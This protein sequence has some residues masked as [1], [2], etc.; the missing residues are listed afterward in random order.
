MEK[1]IILYAI[2]TLNFYSYSQ[3]LKKVIELETKYLECLDNGIGMKNCP[4]NF[5]STSDSLLNVAY[6]NLKIKMNVA[7]Q[8]NLQIEQ[9]KWLKK[10]DEYFKKAYVEAKKEN[11][12]ETQGS[13]FTMF[14]FNKK[15]EFVIQRVKELINRINKIK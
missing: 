10:R 3:T 5:Y 11:S 14:Y 15:S 7:E 1:K 4:I 6:K 13:D 8:N 12:G 9:R 2:L